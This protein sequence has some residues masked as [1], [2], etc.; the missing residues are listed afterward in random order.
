ML[1]SCVSFSERGHAG[2]VAA[3]VI[4][5]IVWA[6]PIGAAAAESRID[7]LD[8]LT[9]VTLTRALEYLDI[10]RPELGFDKLY[11]DDDTFRLSVVEDILND[12]LRLPGWQERVVA[13]ARRWGHHEKPSVRR[14]MQ[15]AANRRKSRN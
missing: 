6:C 11:A 12:P 9:S 3:L 7:G 1:L 2:V 8:S 4:L 14:K 5:V 10:T 13:E 15:A